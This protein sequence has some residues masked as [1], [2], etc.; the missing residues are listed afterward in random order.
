MSDI[1]NELKEKLNTIPELPGIYKFYD[2]GGNIIYV[3]KSKC[4]KNRVKSY[5]TKS[6]KWEK[7]KKMI[8]FIQDV[9]FIVTDTHLEARLLE[10]ELIKTLK[11]Y[12]NAQMKN[13]QRYVYLKVAEYNS[14]NPLTVIAEREEFSFGPFRSR[15]TL[16]DIVNSLKNIYPIAKKDHTYVFEYHLLPVSLTKDEFEENRINLL[17]LFSDPLKFSL[18]LSELE[19]KMMEAASFYKYETA[20]MYR[21]MMNG[22]KY[23]THGISAY[24]N[25]LNRSILLKIP[26]PEGTKLFYISDGKVVLKEKFSILQG[27]DIKKFIKKGKSN[28]ELTRTVPDS[29][30]N[31]EITEKKHIDFRDI[32]CS[33][34]MALPEDMV[35]LL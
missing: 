35:M 5:F 14:Y 1:T 4:L 33:E 34:I 9:E 29:N 7:V 20:S 24:E 27:K 3:G 26:Y 10:C 13:D 6:P 21:D 19:V 2:A 30:S 17:E 28:M 11:P 22:L 18:F 16:L 25:L 15:Y 8:C 12:F 31:L 23:I 32:L